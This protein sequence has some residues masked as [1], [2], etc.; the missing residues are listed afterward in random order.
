VPSVLPPEAPLA[1]TQRA[2]AGDEV[3]SRVQ[4]RRR[5]VALDVT[6]TSAFASMGGGDVWCDGKKK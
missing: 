4:R 3:L 5:G 1:R 6:P 2:T